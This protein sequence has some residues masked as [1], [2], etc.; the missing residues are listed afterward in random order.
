VKTEGVRARY[1]NGF[2]EV[3]MK[4]KETSKEK[5]VRVE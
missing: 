5:D 1:E 2:L 3:V 4:K